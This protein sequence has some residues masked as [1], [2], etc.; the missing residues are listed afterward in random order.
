MRMLEK[1]LPQ[2]HLS[3]KSFLHNEGADARVNISMMEKYPTMLEK[4]SNRI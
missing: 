4:F 1:Q 2:S 3:L